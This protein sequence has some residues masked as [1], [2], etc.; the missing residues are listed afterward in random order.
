MADVGLS[1]SCG[2]IK[3]I[4]T[5]V[6]A[7]NGTR[8]VCYC[9]DCQ[10][11]S[12]LLGR[13]Q[14]ILDSYAGTDIYQLSPAQVNITQGAE[15]LQ[16]LRLSPKGLY[17]WYSQCCKTPIAN[18]VG[19]KLPFVGLIHNFISEEK[20]LDLSLGPVRYF[21]L[22]KHALGKPDNK[23]LADGIPFKML[24]RVIPRILLAK[25]LGKGLPNPFFTADG[26][27]VVKPTIASID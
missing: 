7:H 8:V 12:R 9:S 16:C 20:E 10:A 1:C 22:G 23:K 14:E 6:S 21:I 17:R 26:K 13:Q 4:A 25:V 15:L 24:L 3:G 18:T 11:F 27:A 5:G 19:L 2:K